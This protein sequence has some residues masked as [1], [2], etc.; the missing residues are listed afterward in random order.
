VREWTYAKGV[1]TRITIAREII[2]VTRLN[3]RAL[4]VCGSDKE[5]KKRSG[6]IRKKR[7]ATGRA[8]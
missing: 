4:C 5:E 7:E 6:V 1:P 3:R 2:D 8:R